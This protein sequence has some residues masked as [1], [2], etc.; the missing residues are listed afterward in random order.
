ML[1]TSSSSHNTLLCLACDFCY[2]GCPVRFC[3]LLPRFTLNANNL[4]WISPYGFQPFPLFI[5]MTKLGDIREVVEINMK[6]HGQSYCHSTQQSSGLEGERKTLILFSW[7]KDRKRIKGF[8][9]LIL[10]CFS[11]SKFRKLQKSTQVCNSLSLPFQYLNHMSNYP[12]GLSVM[13]FWITPAT[14]RALLPAV[15][16]CAA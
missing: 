14:L 12:C 2:R 4:Y 15:L 7:G 6:K 9:R 11:T 8:H 5:K 3:P 13:D 16:K 10:F 1:L